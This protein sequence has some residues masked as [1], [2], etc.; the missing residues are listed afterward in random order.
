MDRHGFAPIS[1]RSSPTKWACL[2]PQP[3]IFEAAAE[4]C[5]SA[6]ELLH[7]GD[8][9]PTD[10]AGAHAVGA[11]AALFAGD[12]GTYRESTAADY[13]FAHWDDFVDLLP[14]MV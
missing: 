3:R 10:I 8:L 12:N 4:A 7:I 13:V 9:E 14:G 1:P 6:P 11:T 5:R 2:K